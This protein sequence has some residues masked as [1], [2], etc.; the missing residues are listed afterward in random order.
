MIRRKELTLCNVAF[1]ILRTEETKSPIASSQV[2]GG[3]AGYC[4]FNPCPEAPRGWTDHLR[5]HSGPTHGLALPT[6]HFSN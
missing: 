6:P 5:P 1:V 3:E 2:A 4:T